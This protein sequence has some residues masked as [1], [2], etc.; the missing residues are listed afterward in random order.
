MQLGMVS[1]E[2][3]QWPQGIQDY[4]LALEMLRPAG[5]SRTLAEAEYS[6]ALVLEFDGD[7]HG[8]MEHVIEAERI[9]TALSGPAVSSKGKE[10]VTD[11]AIVD[12]ELAEILADIKVKKSELEEKIREPLVG[13]VEDVVDALGRI[14]NRGSGEG[15]S[16]REAP[17]DVSGLVRKK[18]KVDEEVVEEVKSVD[19]VKTLEEVVVENKEVVKDAV[20]EEVK[21]VEI[22]PVEV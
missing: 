1:M 8:A 19:E 4:N 17:A 13:G 9:L 2:Q 15:G 16:K 21:V 6:L 18:V 11:E 22:N 10:K 5:D 7:V 3:E 12:G 14:V 20:T